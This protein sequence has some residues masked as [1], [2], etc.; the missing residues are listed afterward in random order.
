MEKED[1]KNIFVLNINLWIQQKAEKRLKF[2]TYLQY[3]SYWLNHA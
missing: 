3:R 1:K 2:G